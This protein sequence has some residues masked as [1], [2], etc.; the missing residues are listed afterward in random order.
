M[1]WRQSA[2]HQVCRPACHDVRVYARYCLGTTSTPPHLTHQ[3]LAA[4]AGGFAYAARTMG[5]CAAPAIA[6]MLLGGALF[7]GPGGP[8]PDSQLAA[9]WAGLVTLMAARTLAIAGP[10][11]ARR[12]PFARLFDDG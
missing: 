7:A 3:G 11:W 1:A 5:L 6:C 8:T 2:R 4:G 10:Y 9:V 12:G